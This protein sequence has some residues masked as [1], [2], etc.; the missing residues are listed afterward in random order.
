MNGEPGRTIKRVERGSVT[1]SNEVLSSE[2]KPCVRIQYCSPEKPINKKGRKGKKEEQRER[3]RKGKKGGKEE[4][5][6]RGPMR[7]IRRSNNGTKNRD[8][9]PVNNN[10]GHKEKRRGRKVEKR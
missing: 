9:M 1:I 3:G 10:K 5:N 4:R 2:R 6:I 7:S 8:P